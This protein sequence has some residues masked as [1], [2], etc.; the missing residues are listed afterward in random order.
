M[1][2][3]ILFTSSLCFSLIL[4][5]IGSFLRLQN[6]ETA[7]IWILLGL[8]TCIIFIVLALIEILPSTRISLIEKL[9]WFISLIIM[10]VMAGLIY[11]VS[12]RRKKIIAR[13]S[14]NHIE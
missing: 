13:N 7:H 11:Q 2:R 9:L 5:V 4:I 1:L 3:N 8:V 10:G 12:G 6:N 14:N